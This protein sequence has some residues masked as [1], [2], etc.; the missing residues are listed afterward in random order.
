MVAMDSFSPKT[1]A[2]AIQ[3][4][5]PAAM[6]DETGGECSLIRSDGSAVTTSIAYFPS[7]AKSQL[8][9]S[10]TFDSVG[11]LVR[12]SE[13]RGRTTVNL[14]RG[15]TPAQLDSARRANEAAVRSPSI[16]LDYPVDRAMILNRGGGA[17]TQAISS[18][19]R[20]V[21]NLE[22]FGPI[23]ARMERIRKLC[24]V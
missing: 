14:G 18:P 6:A 5:I 4:F 16:S 13:M 7:R 10:M 11:H 21:E 3:D 20:D 12:Y 23:R 9:V 19:I 22:K 8:N 17:P 15:S 1:G 2:A 24:G